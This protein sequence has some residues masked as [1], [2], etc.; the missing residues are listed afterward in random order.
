MHGHFLQTIQIRVDDEIG[1]V[2]M[3]EQF[4]RHQADELIRRH[5]AVGTADPQV[6]VRV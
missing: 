5:A 2:A 3:D 6:R 1:D 4:F